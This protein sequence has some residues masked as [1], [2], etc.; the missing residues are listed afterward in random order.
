MRKKAMAVTAVILIGVFLLGTAA[1]GAGPVQKNLKAYFRNIKIKSNG[2]IVTAD[3]VEPFIYD[4]RVYVPIRLV[5][6]ALDKNVHWDSGTN[7]VII[8]DKGIGQDVSAVLAQK[9]AELAQLRQQNYYLGYKV[10]ELEKALQDKQE[11]AAKKKSDPVEALKDHLTDEY[12]RWNNIKFTYKVKESKD[13]LVLTIEF[14]RSSYKSKW[15]GLSQKKI[16]SWLNDIYDYVTDELDIDGFSGSI[17]DTDKRETLV[18]FYNS[19]T[20]LIVEFEQD[21]AEDFEALEAD[22]NDMFGSGLNMYDSAFG[23][24]KASI[25]VDGD[26]EYEELYI[27]VTVDT[28]RYGTEWDDIKDT[29]AGDEWLT[30]IVSYTAK[31]FKSYYIWGKVK[32]KSGKTLA[33]FDLTSGRTRITW[34]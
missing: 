34:N 28:A 33:S 15:N 12:S 19:R 10:A 22:L 23:S 7:T 30:D 31:K 17:R 13:A 4:N 16:E 29:D 21:T 2:K 27:T 20:R 1:M 25:V 32:N 8:E 14:D 5:S 26:D 24:M 3:S 11:E 18:E 9:D 6:T